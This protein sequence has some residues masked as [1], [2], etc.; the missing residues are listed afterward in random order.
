MRSC[1]ESHNMIGVPCVPIVLRSIGPGKEPYHVVYITLWRKH[2][3]G[4]MGY[5]RSRKNVM[6]FTSDVRF[7]DFAQEI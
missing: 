1:T 2:V 5:N 4:C 3:V 6:G 7:F